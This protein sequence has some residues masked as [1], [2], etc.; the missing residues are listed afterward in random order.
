[1]TKEKKTNGFGTTALILG[2]VGLFFFPMVFGILAIIFGAIAMGKG[3]RGGKAG[4][5]LGIIDIA[6]SIIM[7]MLGVYALLGLF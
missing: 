5:V 1:M 2:I 6:L 4:L 3:Q 7:I